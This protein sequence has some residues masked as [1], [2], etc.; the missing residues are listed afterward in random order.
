MLEVIDKS[1]FGGKST[2]EFIIRPYHR[3]EEQYVANF[4]KKLYSEEYSWGPSFTD[5]AVKIA[6]DFAKKEKSEKEE[7]F[8]AEMNGTLIGCIML[9]QT[10]VPEI[11]QLRLFAV[12]KE[13]RRY[14]VGTALINAFM[15]RAKSVGYQKLVL[16]TASP[17][18]AAIHHYEKIGFQITES[19]ENHTWSTDGTI[20]DEI[21]MEMDMGTAQTT[22]DRDVEKTQ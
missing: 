22:V 10:D 21:K 16:W 20:L 1:E 6:L 2:M 12:E 3:G 4:H 18:T 13:Y 14:G 17:L 5:Y 8:V 19:V 11:G 9:C 15:E 7:L